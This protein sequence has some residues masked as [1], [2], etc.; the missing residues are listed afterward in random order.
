MIRLKTKLTFFLIITLSLSLSAQDSTTISSNRLK[1]VIYGGSSLYGIT[2]FG[3]NHLWYTNEPQSKF[4]FFNDNN[5]W[6]QVD[7]VGHGVTAFHISRIGV[8]VFEWAGLPRKKAIFWGSLSGMI[9]QTP[10]EILDGFSSAYGA[11]WGDIVANTAGSGFL[12][13]Q[14]YLWDELR[15]TPKF[16]FSKSKYATQRPNVLGSNLPEQVLKD[17]NGQTYWLSTNIYSF[18]EDKSTF[19]KWVNFALGY[20]G[21]QMIYAETTT[22]KANGL[23][24]Y[25]QFYVSLDVDLTKIKSKSKF[26]NSALFL[27]NTLKVPFPA[28]EFTKNG[29][30]FH[31][32]KF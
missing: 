12:M 14:Y 15:I 6:L 1:T 9:F 23:T 21:E 3:L 2:I 30:Q 5:E 11:S 19:P 25:R 13:S 26:V 7:K 22:N 31:W 17:Y 18:L 29:T 28:L 27:I 20:G 8:E 32:F 10:I 4:H 24:P 16:S